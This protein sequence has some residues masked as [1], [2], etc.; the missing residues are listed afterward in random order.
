MR[1]IV[2]ITD[3]KTGEM[4]R[5][6]ALP[7]YTDPRMYEA[8]KR[9]V[10][11]GNT[12]STRRGINVKPF[13]HMEEAF[14][15][16]PD[17]AHPRLPLA[18]YIVEC[19]PHLLFKEAKGRKDALIDAYAHHYHAVWQFPNGRR[20]SVISGRMFNC[21]PDAPYEVW[22]LSEA[23]GGMVDPKGY[24]DD[25]ELMLLLIQEMMK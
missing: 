10:D 11:M 2:S 25:A 20:V 4:I 5:P 1:R 24:V 8:I 15:V 23:E 19:G 21:S 6:T 9:V 7:H 13:A 12:F 18:E 16:P 14:I 22:L 17:R 3:H